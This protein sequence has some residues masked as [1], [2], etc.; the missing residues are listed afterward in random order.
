MNNAA[1]LSE[2]K[3]EGMQKGMSSQELNA[4]LY[5]LAQRYATAARDV[6]GEQ[7]VSVAL[8]GSV[9]RG[10]A[11]PTSDIDLFV[12]L[13]EAPPAMIR[14]RAL[15]EPVREQLT[16]ELEVLWKQGHY[17]DFVEVI[18]SQ[19]EATA[20]HPLYLDMAM[21]AV[22]LYDAQGFFGQVLQRVRERLAALNSQRRQ[23]GRHWY[24]DLKPEFTPGEVI[25]L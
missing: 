17:A 21:E 11:R 19:V 23:L 3:E 25:E 8:Y 9:A 20:F 13:R 4:V 18:R 7:L 16:L 1:G 12:V 15:L 14:R 2:Q 10:Q 22:V 6:L 24:W 5:K